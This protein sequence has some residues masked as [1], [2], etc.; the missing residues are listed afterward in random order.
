MSG[1]KRKTHPRIDA[2]EIVDNESCLRPLLPIHD[3][4]GGD[5]DDDH[6]RPACATDEP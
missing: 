6:G 1:V 4:G 5:D 2:D 3:D